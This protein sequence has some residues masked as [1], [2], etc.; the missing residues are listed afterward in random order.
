MR[1]LKLWVHNR[2]YNDTG[3]D[4][5]INPKEFPD[6]G[7]GDVLEIYH[8]ED[9]YSRLLLQVTALPDDFNQKDIIS[10]EQSIATQ[11][12]LRAYKEV[13]VSKV[14]PK[15][16]ALDL[17]ELLFK[18]QYLSR[19]DMWRLRHG[20]VNTCAYL[21]KKI[22][23]AQ[24]RAQVFELWAKGDRVTCGMI[25]DD[26]RIVF[27]SST[28]V[29]QIFI[30]MSSEMWDFDINGDLY[31]EKAVNGFLTDLFAKWKT[32]NC[33]HDV[34]I[35]LFSRTFYKAT[36]REDFPPGVR[37]CIQVDYQGRFYEDF[38]RVL[39]QNERYDDWTRTIKTLRKL[40]NEYPRRVLNYHKVKG[41]KMPKAWN[42]TASQGNFLETLNMSLNLLEKHYVDRNFDRTGKVA[43]VITPGP[44]VFE[45]DREL[46]NITKQR[47]IDCGVGSDL[48]CMGE[49]PLHA[50][51][52]FKFHNRN[53]KATLQVG[54]DYNIPHWMNHSFYLSKNQIQAH[55]HGSFIPRI[56]PPQQIEKKSKSKDRVADFPAYPPPST[57]T[58]NDNFPFMDYDEY[59]AQVFKLPTRNYS[60]IGMKKKKTKKQPQTYM[61]AKKAHKGRIRRSS[62]DMLLER[63][64]TSDRMDGAISIPV[65]S[66]SGDEISSSV[67]AIDKCHAKDLEDTSEEE[68]EYVRP[69]FGSAGSPY[70]HSKHLSSM[71][72][73][74]RAL[75]NPFAPSTMHFKMTSN[76]RRWIHAFPTD[77]QGAAVQTHH[78][79]TFSHTEE[80]EGSFDLHS[81]ETDYLSVGTMKKGSLIHQD[82]NEGSENTSSDQLSVIGSAGNVAAAF[83]TSL[84]GFSSSL[85]SNTS[86]L[87]DYNKLPQNN[88]PSKEGQRSWV[89]GPTGEQEWSPNMTTGHDWRPLEY[90]KAASSKSCLVKPILNADINSKQF[91]A[92][93]SVDWKSL[94]IPA[95][96]PITTDYFPDKKSLQTD[97]VFAA[98]GL[99]PEQD[100]D[101]GMDYQSLSTDEKYFKRKNLTSKQVFKELVSQR[102]SQGFQ[103]IVNKTPR[104]K[105]HQV[106]LGSSP[107][108]QHTVGLIRARPRTEQSEECY[109]SIGRIFHKVTV[110]ASDITVTRYS[111]RHPAPEL[112]LPYCYRFQ[113]PDSLSYDVSWSEFRNEKLENYNWNYLDQYI[114]TRGEGDYGLVEV[115]VDWYICTRGEGDYGLVE[116]LKFWRSRFLIMPCNNAATK[117]IIDGHPRCD[118]Y[119]EKSTTEHQNL[120]HGFVR[121]TEILNRLKRTAKRSK[122][123]G[124]SSVSSTASESSKTA[125][126]QG[127]EATSRPKDVDTLTTGSPPTKLIEAMLDAQFGL[128]F[129]S[130]QPGLPNNCFIAEEAVTWCIQNIQG[131]VTT[132]HAINLLQ[133]LVDDKLI[134]HASW[135]PNH[136]FVYGFYFYCIPQ[137]KDKAKDIEQQPVNVL[138]Q[139]NFFEVNVLAVD[140]QENQHQTSSHLTDSTRSRSLSSINPA[141][142]DWRMEMSLDTDNTEWG[143]Q[144]AT[145]LHKYVTIDVD[146]L[147]KSDRPEWATV[148]YHSYYS[149][150]CAFQLQLQWMVATGSILG[151]LVYSWARK[152]SSCGFHL[153]P[154]PVDPFALP[155]APD[156]DSLRGPIFVPL[157]IDCLTD[158]RA[159]ITKGHGQSWREKLHSFQIAIIK[160]FGFMPAGVRDISED[161]YPMGQGEDYSHYVHCTGGNFVLMEDSHVSSPVAKDSPYSSSFNKK[162]NAELRKDYIKRSQSSQFQQ[163]EQEP[164]SK[165]GYLWSW[166]FMS[167]KRWRSG[168]TGD[169]F[170]QDKMLAD[171]RNFCSN[172]ENRL[173]EFWLEWYNPFQ[174]PNLSGRET[175]M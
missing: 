165:I 158:G 16:V 106:S 135:N 1:T 15:D 26:T 5:L 124:D 55:L 13:H 3:D 147:D 72:L 18:D 109:L 152:M 53:L 104:S 156:S 78:F 99:L 19:S 11:F 38:Y 111:P 28:A 105:A 117:R 160:R 43:V 80:M 145:L 132:S 30:Q 65:R 70:F 64:L 25:T 40:F 150:T 142:D 41:Q 143:Q 48:V 46:T 153:I 60:L 62:D 169:E 113:A 141:T 74:R 7:K 35:V 171:F 134:V 17:V 57:S 108:Y 93:I 69:I 34:T 14:S 90:D 175:T 122:L 140:E 123:S 58:D 83:N 116:S 125:P 54:D 114:C 6:V 112:K 166:N 49:Q 120:I 31:F 50:A 12:Q 163:Q 87:Q 10:I 127:G 86:F 130:K 8:P 27:R 97:Y 128:P 118:I 47:T 73:S 100:G 174:L 88:N 103:V 89:W 126:V 107:Q 20:L 76:R 44:G 146:V 154:V 96:L 39:V 149:P 159:I 91:C 119:E 131:V 81:K 37:D 138:F 167:S 157:D 82:S 21:T 56:K 2:S 148:R 66:S 63:V 52:L 32:Q 144:L 71:T 33:L 151:E 24:M 173:Q 84:Q 79:R 51:P 4:I 133:V 22:E 102:L 42:S 161:A 77:P 170:F 92:C 168:N 162:S 68:G 45:V 121:M 94:T 29:V 101:Y 137:V 172:K 110:L 23:T 9:E 129:L 95:S 98:Y 115:S 36:S 136:K 75:I 139:R 155:S 85:G 61:E 67:P 59:D 164:E